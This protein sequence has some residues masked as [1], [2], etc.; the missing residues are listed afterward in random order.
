MDYIILDGRGGAT[1]AAPKSF[2]DS[3]SVPT[4]PAL[5]RARY[6]LDRRDRADITLIVTGGLRLPSDFIKALSLGTDGVAIANSAIQAVGCV[7]ARM[8]NTNQCPVAHAPL[9]GRIRQAPGS[10]PRASTQL[11]QVMAR[12]FGHDR[13][14]KFHPD[15]ITTWKR[16]M[17]DLTGIQY[18]GIDPA[19]RI[20]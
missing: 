20:N 1:G 3:I 6:H 14:D 5:A 19:R 11:M 18:A 2:R 12:A 13:L 10:L 17:A 4:I 15:D 16:Q 7:A 8:C 9:R